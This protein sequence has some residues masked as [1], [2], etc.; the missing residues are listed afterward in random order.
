MILFHSNQNGIMAKLHFSHHYDT[1]NYKSKHFMVG[2]IMDNYQIFISYRRDGGEGLAGRIADRLSSQGYCVFYDVESMRSGTFNTQIFEAIDKCQDV[3]LILPPNALDRCVNPDDWVRQEILYSISH[4]KNIIPVMMRNFTFPDVLPPELA[5]IRYM[6]GV[7]ASNEYFD[8]VMEKITSMLK[9]KQAHKKI[10]DEIL[11]ITKQNNWTHSVQTTPS[12]SV[13]INYARINMKNLPKLNL[14]IFVL[15]ESW[16]TIIGRRIR[17]VTDADFPKVYEL[18]CKINFY[19]AFAKFYIATY[20]DGDYIEANYVVYHDIANQ[21][22]VCIKML[23]EIARA[24]DK[25]YPDI[26]EALG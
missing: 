10:V 6:E 23:D 25:Y 2:G 21:A 14:C 24:V 26:L 3:V 7:V 1:I 20:D 18:L 16:I 22:G 19:S 9:S 5:A 13:V 17:K 4:N 8:A 11:Y 12:G 15:D